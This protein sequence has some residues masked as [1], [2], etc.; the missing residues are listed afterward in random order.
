MSIYRAYEMILKNQSG[1]NWFNAKIHIVHLAP[2]SARFEIFSGRKV[3]LHGSNLQVRKLHGK[4][5]A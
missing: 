2:F 1:G 4:I 3:V 5:T